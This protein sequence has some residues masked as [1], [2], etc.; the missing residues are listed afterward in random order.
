MNSHLVSETFLDDFSSALVLDNTTTVLP[1]SSDMS[2]IDF[3]EDLSWRPNIAM[4][5]IGLQQTQPLEGLEFHSGFTPQV[6]ELNDSESR[7]VPQAFELPPELAPMAFELNPQLLDSMPL[8]STPG[9]VAL[10]ESEAAAATSARRP[11]KPREY[12]PRP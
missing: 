3:L 11:R 6:S 9:F 7:A 12:V 4:A 1:F 2:S 10:Q 8:V 5:E